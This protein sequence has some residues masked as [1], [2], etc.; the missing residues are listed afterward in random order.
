MGNRGW[1]MTALVTGLLLGSAACGSK[2]APAVQPPPPPPPP[3]AEVARTPLPPPAPP[4]P[5]PPP[6]LPTP[7]PPTEAELFARMSLDALNA[8]HPLTDVFYDY[9]KADLSEADRANLQKDSAWLTHWTSTR[10]EIEGHCDERGTAEY[11]LALGER[12]AQAARG[13]LIS[14]GVAADRIAV[15]SRG[16]EFPFCTEHA[17]T[18]WSQNRRGHFII[19]TK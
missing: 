18:C 11:N 15:V 17:E 3:P 9:D 5:T 6:P 4:R 12:R 14:L 19:T 8:S 16:K 13:Y 1:V 10:I 7:A 2:K